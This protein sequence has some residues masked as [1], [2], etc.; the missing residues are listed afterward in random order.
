VKRFI[1]SEV[2][3]EKKENKPPI[4]GGEQ[5]GWQNYYAGLGPNRS[6]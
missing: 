1:E 3:R 2:Q 5:S 4:E 6:K